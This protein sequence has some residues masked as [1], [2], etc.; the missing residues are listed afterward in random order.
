MFNQNSE[1][2]YNHWVCIGF[3]KGI[4]GQQVKKQFRHFGEQFIVAFVNFQ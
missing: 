3:V 1:F 4:F 2:P